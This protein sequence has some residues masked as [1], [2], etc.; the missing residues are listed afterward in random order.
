M[1][2]EPE[3]S[4]NVNPGDVVFTVIPTPGVDWAAVAEPLK[5]RVW[6]VP[7]SIVVKTDEATA[8]VQSSALE[9][10]IFTTLAVTSPSTEPSME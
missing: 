6:P 1:L 10:D 4:D 9:P 8:V 5:F 2:A 7:V 3:P